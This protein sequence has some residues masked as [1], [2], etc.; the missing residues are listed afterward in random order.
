MGGDPVRARLRSPVSAF[1]VVQPEKANGTNSHSVLVAS[2][3]D[4]LPHGQSISATMGGIIRLE[5]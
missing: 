1:S 5:R 4:S 3:A 2:S